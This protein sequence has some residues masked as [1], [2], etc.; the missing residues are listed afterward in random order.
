MMPFFLRSYGGILTIDV[1]SVSVPPP[2]PPSPPTN[3]PVR[4]VENPPRTLTLGLI[5]FSE[6]NGIIR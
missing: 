4:G 5:D 2:P 1:I 6:M 3:P